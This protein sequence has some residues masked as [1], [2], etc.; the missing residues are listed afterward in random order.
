M[1]DYNIEDFYKKGAKRIHRDQILDEL[2]KVL[3]YGKERYEHL[4][5]QGL[6]RE[7][8]NDADTRENYEM[9]VILV[10][11]IMESRRRAVE[12]YNIFVDK[13]IAT[14]LDLLYK[15]RETEL[16]L[17]LLEAKRTKWQ[18]VGKFDKKAKA[19]K[20]ETLATLEALEARVEFDMERIKAEIAK[21]NP[22]S[23]N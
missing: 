5:A 20:E 14:Y 15:L 11:E 22:T 16:A 9:K 7:Y 18:R 23:G 10:K 8:I 1:L 12:L 6:S 19:A 17:V 21:H 2:S 3:A 13:E 4:G